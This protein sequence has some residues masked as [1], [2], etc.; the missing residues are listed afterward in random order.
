M[1]FLRRL[2]NPHSDPP[3]EKT[4]PSRGDASKRVETSLPSETPIISAPGDEVKIEPDNI[5][6]KQPSIK[7]TAEITAVPVVES[8]DRTPANLAMFGSTRPLPPIETYISKPGKH[9][10]YGLN[11]DVGRQRTNN[12]DSMLTFFTANVSAEER[13]DFGLFAV[14]DGMGGYRDGEK[15]S[16]ITTRIVAQY[17]IDKLYLNMLASLSADADRL[18]VA[19]I[20]GDAIQKANVAVSQQIPEGGTTVT[21]VI[22]LGDLAYIGHVGDSRAYLITKDSIEQVTLDHSLVQRLIEL[23]QLTPEE[24][25]LHPQRNV[26]YRAIGQSETLEVDAVT[27]RLPPASRLLICSDGLWGQVPEDVL[28]DI[29]RSSTLPQEACDRLIVAANERGGPDNITA[30]LIQIPG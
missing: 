7:D 29:V 6:I 1:D 3:A 8:V 9:I 5:V 14:A 10:T 20:L 22:I 24:A 23:D 4:L 17:I 12:Q 18:T 19:E 16:A 30:V 27:R 13:P 2:I 21:A 25:A 11:S 28:L 15:A 26:L